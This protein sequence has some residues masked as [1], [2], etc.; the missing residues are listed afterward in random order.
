MTGNGIEVYVV[1]SGD[2]TPDY[3]ETNIMGV[4]TSRGD[5]IRECAEYIMDRLD[6]RDDIRYALT[7]NENDKGLRELMHKDTGVPVEDIDRIFSFGGK[8]EAA[9]IDQV[10]RYPEEIPEELYRWLNAY[11]E[12]M[13]G[14]DGGYHIM[15]TDDYGVLGGPM[16]FDFDV[17]ENC[18]SGDIDQWTCVTSGEDGNDAPD[19]EFEEPFPEVFPTYVDAAACALN[20][21]EDIVEEGYAKD[22]SLTLFNVKIKAAKELA[23][24]GWFEIEMKNNRKRRWDIW[25]T[26][27]S[28][29]KGTSRKDV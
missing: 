11:L 17:T 2:A 28:I 9:L 29:K 6:I 12:D 24:N 3:A 8:P 5:A 10:S 15:C 27:V 18:V 13:I 26:P 22:E 1:S 16:W 20:Q 23:V 7:H 19:F 14:G 21:I 25:H 4:F